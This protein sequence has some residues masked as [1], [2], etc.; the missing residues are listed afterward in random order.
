MI[1]FMNVSTTKIHPVHVNAQTLNKSLIYP[2]Q[3][4]SMSL[5]L[6]ADYLLDNLLIIGNNYSINK[7]LFLLFSTGY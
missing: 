2:P 4:P 6:L 1:Y 3:D 7:C 5:Y